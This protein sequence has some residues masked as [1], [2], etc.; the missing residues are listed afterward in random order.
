MNELLEK[1]QHF[2]SENHQVQKA[3]KIFKYCVS[4]GTGAI[5]DFGLYS[6][7]I[8][9][10]S[11]N[12][13]VSNFISFSC[14]TLVT[15]YLQKNWT[16]EYKTNN[17]VVVFQRFILAVIITYILNNVLLF[18]FIDVL[19]INVFFAKILQIVVSTI[20]G[21]SINSIYVFKKK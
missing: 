6:I 13:L 20:W 11:T 2:S 9:L 12:Y 10:F 5:I 1:I 8:Y 18:A 19:T 15:Y 21:Y 3:K 17:N 7:L 4:G 16:F 14:A